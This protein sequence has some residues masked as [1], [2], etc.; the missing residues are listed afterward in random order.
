M[1][2]T[3]PTAA[4][5]AAL[6]HG[7]AYG[8]EILD[9]TGLR[10]GTVY[11]VLRRMEEE[12]LVRSSWERASLARA[13][14]RPPRRNYRLTAAGHR[15]ADAAEKRFPTLSKMFVASGEAAIAKV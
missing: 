13:E 12:G 3:L 4:V 5:L 6:V 9:V 2:L 7:H 8:F 10:P 14:G 15:I 1:R 11:P